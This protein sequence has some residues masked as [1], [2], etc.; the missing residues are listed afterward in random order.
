M[1]FQA[2]SANAAGTDGCVWRDAGKDIDD[3]RY[4]TRHADGQ[5][6]GD[7][8]P[9]CQ[10][11]STSA[12]DAAVACQPRLCRRYE[13]A[14]CMAEHSRLICRSEDLQDGGAGVRFEL[15]WHGELTPA[16]AVR[17]AGKAYAYLNRCGH[18]PVQL[19]WQPGEFF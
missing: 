7:G 6:R 16:F 4:D 15:E 5:K 11:W 9:G 2:A 10:L 14:G 1:S 3:W 18:V 12:R 8:G 13:G 19:D 17:Y